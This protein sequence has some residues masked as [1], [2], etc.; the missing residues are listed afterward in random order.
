M[1]VREIADENAVLRLRTTNVHLPV[2]FDVVTAWGFDHKSLPTW[3]KDRVGTGERLRGQ[4][5]HCLL[6]ACGKPAFLNGNHA[7]A[8]EAARREYSREADEFYPLVEAACLG[9]R[10]ELFSRQQRDGWC[11]ASGR[12]Y[13]R[14]PGASAGREKLILNHMA[15]HRLS[16]IYT[17]AL[18]GSAFTK[19]IYQIDT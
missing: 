16:S 13:P 17:R 15:A 2:A 18:R 14:P 4:T 8:L 10:V 19:L 1:R 3:V 9:S 11:A 6:A 7:T 12:S 5:E